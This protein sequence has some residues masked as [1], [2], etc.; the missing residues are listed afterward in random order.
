MNQVVGTNA[1]LLIRL[2]DPTTYNL[3][4]DACAQV[5]DVPGPKVHSNC[6]HVL[7]RLLKTDELAHDSRLSGFCRP[8]STTQ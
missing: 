8:F 6:W 7:F 2:I 4:L 5:F 3:H 1:V